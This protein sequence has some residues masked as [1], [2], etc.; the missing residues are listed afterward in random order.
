MS[1]RSIATSG[2][3]L[4]GSDLLGGGDDKKM[5]PLEF[6][7]FILKSPGFQILVGLGTAISQQRRLDAFIEDQRAIGD[8]RVGAETAAQDARTQQTAGVVGRSRLANEEILGSR[9]DRF[10]DIADP[11]SGDIQELT[12]LGIAGNQGIARG[13]AQ[14]ER[15]ILAE[16][17]GIGDARRADINRRFGA[18][19]RTEQGRLAGLGLGGTLLSSGVASGVERARGNTLSVFNDQQREFQL[20]LSSDLSSETLAARLAALESNTQLRQGQV[21]ALG[22]LQFGEFDVREQA[23]LDQRAEEERLGLIVSNQRVEDER[24]ISD[25]RLNQIIEEPPVIDPANNQL[26]F[27]AGQNR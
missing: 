3:T 11:L 10:A 12:Q 22:Q 13:F 19:G 21:N 16:S 15:D 24:R 5:N 20:G 23:L 26:L 6:L 2:F 9:G 14:R 4:G 27:G 25:L 7:N 8:E 1:S 18:L 17:R